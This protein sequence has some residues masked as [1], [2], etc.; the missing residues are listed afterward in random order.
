VRLTRHAKNRLRRLGIPRSEV[1]R[2]VRDSHF[3]GRDETGK[4]QYQGVV[5]DVK[6]RLVVAVDEPDLIVTIHERRR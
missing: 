3:V 6:I 2:L 4:P 1:E 5:R